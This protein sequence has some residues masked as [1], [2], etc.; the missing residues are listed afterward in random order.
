MFSSVH[1]MKCNEKCKALIE[2]LL[3]TFENEDVLREEF[4]DDKEA[5]FRVLGNSLVI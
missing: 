4:K 1:L 2:P 5:L 3:K